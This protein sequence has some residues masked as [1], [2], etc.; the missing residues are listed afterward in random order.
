VNPGQRGYVGKDGKLTERFTRWDDK[1]IVYEFTV[2]DPG[3]FTQPW[4]G[5][6]ALNWS[7]EP[8]YEY[9]CHEGNY[10]ITNI[11]QGA[12]KQERDGKV[13]KRNTA[14]E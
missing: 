13:V 10:A 2:D 7:K 8:F 4:K 14:E 1:H 6:M 9:A 11:L 12:R 5:E 3:Q